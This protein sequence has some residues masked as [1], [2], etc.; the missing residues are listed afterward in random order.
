M[1][2]EEMEHVFCWVFTALHYVVLKLF[3]IAFRFLRTPNNTLRDT[4]E[5][6]LHGDDGHGLLVVLHGYGAG[7]TNLANQIDQ[8][9]AQLEQQPRFAYRRLYVPKVVYDKNRSI[10][11]ANTHIYSNINEYH[12]QHDDEPIDIIGVSAGGRLAIAIQYAMRNTPIPMRIV[13]VGSPLNGTALIP[14]VR[15][16]PLGHHLLHT[17]VGETL[18]R[19][20]DPSC[21]REQADMIEYASYVPSNHTFRFLYST[22]DWMV[23][24]PHRCTINVAMTSGCAVCIG[25]VAHG[26][27]LVHPSVINT[28]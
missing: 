16:M 17:L 25:A 20:F 19:D 2:V 8:L 7:R 3:F 12:R 1:E 6:I 23:F 22:V 24:P 5:V 11:D 4:D 21:G 9:V 26:D 28:L 14:L 15:Q 10:F 13:T 18:L 27:M